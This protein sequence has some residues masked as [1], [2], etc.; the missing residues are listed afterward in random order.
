M[1]QAALT[2]PGRREA[3]ISHF[4]ARCGARLHEGLNIRR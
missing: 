4:S 1:I 2:Q 3:L